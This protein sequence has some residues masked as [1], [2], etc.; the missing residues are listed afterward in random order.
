MLISARVKRLRGKSLIEENGCSLIEIN[1][2]A[3]KPFKL[4]LWGHLS[5]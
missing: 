2:A 4:A 5:K 3:Y 1:V